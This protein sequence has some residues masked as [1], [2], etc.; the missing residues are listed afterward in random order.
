MPLAASTRAE[1]TAGAEEFCKSPSVSAT[2]TRTVLHYALRILVLTAFAVFGWSRS[3]LLTSA[4]ID[5][6][7]RLAVL[8]AIS[9]LEAAGFTR[10]VVALR[11]FANF[12][13][14]DNWWNRHVGHSDAYAATNFPLGVVTLYAPFF[15]VAVDAT[16]RAAILL[17]EARHLWGD[18]ETAALE[19][20]WREKERLGWTADAYAH[21]KVFRNTREWTAFAAPSLV[22]LEP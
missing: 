11:H 18:G 2:P 17:H 8:D 15:N 22:R 6:T 7:Q 1:I 13:A 4:P 16:E 9:E 14:T 20:V 19:T 12:R 5:T 10:E 21:T 3:L